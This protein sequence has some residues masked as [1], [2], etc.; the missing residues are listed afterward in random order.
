[1]FKVLLPLKMCTHE[2]DKC[3]LLKMLIKIFSFVVVWLISENSFTLL[4]AP[5]TLENFFIHTAYLQAFP[6]NCV[7]VYNHMVLSK[8]H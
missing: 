6:S 2:G 1:M 7:Y 3:K 8:Q 4:T 5:Q